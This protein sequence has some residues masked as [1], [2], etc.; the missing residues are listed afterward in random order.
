MTWAEVVGALPAK[1]LVWAASLACVAFAA[2]VI[3]TLVSLYLT[4]EPFSIASLEFGPKAPIVF[5]APKDAVVAFAINAEP[6][7]SRKH[8]PRDWSPF[9]EARG[10]FVIGAGNPGKNGFFKWKQ[11]QPEGKPPIE[12][13]LS[14]YMP[15]SIGGEEKHLL[16]IKEIPP[17]DHGVQFIQHSEYVREKQGYPGIKSVGRDVKRTDPKW[18]TRYTEI[19]G[20]GQAHDVM[21]PFVALYYCKKD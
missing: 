18:D 11:T 9:E 3:A 14:R 17:H 6:S 4:K 8:C 15:L 13:D 20:G 19:V 1:L 16:A 7:E 12:F 10:R 21:P 2:L 5:A